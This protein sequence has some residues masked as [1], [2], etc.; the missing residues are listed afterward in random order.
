MMEYES[1]SKESFFS[2]DLN[3]KRHTLVSVNDHL[4]H[5]FDIYCNARSENLATMVSGEFL[6]KLCVILRNAPNIRKMMLTDC[7]NGN[8]WD[9]CDPH[10]RDPWKQEA[11]CPFPDCNLSVSEHISFYVRPSPL[12]TNNPHPLHLAALVV[13][14]AKS[15]ITEL[16]IL[17]DG[18]DPCLVDGSFFM[19][20]RQ[21]SLLTL[22][23]Q[24]LTQLRMRFVLGQLEDSHPDGVISKALSVAINLESLFIEGNEVSE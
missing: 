12:Y 15:F 2:R 13:S 24:H 5:A 18:E 6:A 8:V 10:P 19:T 4:E 7:G 1:L 16:S 3:G 22:Q 9:M 21:S 17:H 23:F 11:L 14:A 20:A